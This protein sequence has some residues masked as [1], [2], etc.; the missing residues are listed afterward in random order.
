M[1]KQRLL[2]HTLAGASVFL[3]MTVV[4][5]AMTGTFFSVSLRGAKRK[6]SDEAISCFA[7]DCFAPLAMTVVL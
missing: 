6:W 5:I 7:R 3:A 4:A 2:R 1:R